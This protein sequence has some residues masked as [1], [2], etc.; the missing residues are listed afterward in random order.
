MGK[1]DPYIF[2]VYNNFFNFYTDQLN[3]END[4]KSI[5]FLGQDKENTFT[6]QIK[7]E[8]REFYDISMENWNINSFPYKFNKKFDLIVCTRCPYF[9]NNPKKFLSEIN[10]FLNPGGRIFVDWGLGDHLRY[11]KFRVG[12]QDINEKEQCYFD[13]NYMTSCL[14]DKS[15]L[16]QE[17]VKVFAERI[18]K[19]GYDNLENAVHSEVPTVINLN[20]IKEIFQDI[21]V[22]CMPLWDDNPQL[23]IIL[24]GTKK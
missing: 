12:F 18:K 15:F 1:S 9:S 19:Y 23:Y 20:D 3:T 14:W 21:S 7:S 22:L 16:D 4:I 2:N 24:Q 6:K 13:G 10:D 8:I 17:G 5:C 11:E